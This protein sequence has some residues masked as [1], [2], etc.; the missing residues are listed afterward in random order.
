MARKRDEFGRNGYCVLASAV[1]TE[2]CHRVGREIA[3][4][5]NSD[6]NDSIEAGGSSARSSRSYVGARNL[7]QKWDGWRQIT[8][9]PSVAEFAGSILG[10]RAGLV[11]ILYFDKPPGKGWSLA[12]HKDR[13]IAVKAHRTPATPFAKPTTKAGV[14]HVE[15]TTGLLANMLTLRLHLDAMHAGNGPLIVVPGSHLETN[16]SSSSDATEIY[17]NA[18]DVFVMRPMLSHGSR[19]AVAKNTDHRRVVHLEIAADESLPGE[20][21]WYQFSPV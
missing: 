13:T 6:F 3:D 1:T 11:R 15:A 9:S 17:C 7:Q 2:V 19:N 16:Q 12:L 8:E 4:L 10:F 18:G 14:P 20:Y 21:E 5:L